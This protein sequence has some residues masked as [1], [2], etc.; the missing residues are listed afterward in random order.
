[1]KRTKDVLFVAFRPGAAYFIDIYPH[2]SD[3]ANWAEKSILE[4]VVRNW[5][6][7]GILHASRFAVG[8]TQEH[9][10][11]ARAELRRTGANL[12]VEID[13]RVWSSLG[14]TVTGIP[15]TASRIGMKVAADLRSLRA[16]GVADLEANLAES[17]PEHQVSLEDWV[18]IV[19]DEHYGF[20]AE[21]IQVF[22][23]YGRL[24]EA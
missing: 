8:V 11:A 20:Y 7:A 24:I 16:A 15:L 10:D 5:P 9:D 14:A 1:V 18:P 6:D 13:G 3:G 21:R 22:V 2:E 17:V 23:R 19:D 12:A 4:T